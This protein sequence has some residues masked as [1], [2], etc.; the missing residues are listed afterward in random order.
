M[1]VWHDYLHTLQIPLSHRI[2]AP[3]AAGLRHAFDTTTH[4]NLIY[5]IHEYVKLP[6][7]HVA[8]QQGEAELD[9]A[10][11]A[12]REE[13]VI[14]EDRK[15]LSPEAIGAVLFVGARA[16][17]KW[18]E[19]DILGETIRLDGALHIGQAILNVHDEENII[20]W[21]RPAGYDPKAFA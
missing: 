19:R 4:S 5:A 18:G 11:E 20:H 3:F 21:Q 16:I 2:P 10:I 7:A 12:I 8:V 13:A 6:E 9:K 17:T 14:V 1:R 15:Y